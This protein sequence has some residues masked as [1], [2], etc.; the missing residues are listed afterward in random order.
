MTDTYDPRSYDPLS[1]DVKPN[2]EE[3]FA[4]LRAKCP[5]HHH[6]FTAEQLAKINNPFVSGRATEMYSFTRYADVERIVQTPEEFLNI[7]GSG[8][9]IMRPP[10]GEGTLT[11]SDGAAHSN[12]RRIAQPAFSPKVINPLAPLLQSRIDDLIDGFAESGAVDIMESFAVPLTS[13]MLAF[14][15]GLPDDDAPMLQE[16]AY[17]ILGMWGGDDEAVAR[18]G[19][20]I[21]GIS[22]FVMKVGPERIAAKERGEELN[23]GFTALLT[24][25]GPNGKTFTLE[26]GIDALAQIVAGGF[27]SSAT[28]IAN[29][30]YLLLSNPGERKKLEERPELIGTA[31]EEVLRYMAPIEGLFRTPASDTTLAGVDLAKG[32]KIRAVFAS[33]NMDDEVF[34]DPTTFRIDR[35]R[36]ELQKHMTFGKGIHSCLGNALARQELKL[37]FTTLF[38]RIPTLQLDP[39]KESRR[40]PLM[41]IHGYDYVPVVWDPQSVLPRESA[42][43][44]AATAG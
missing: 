33:A 25:V 1:S 10:S 32:T 11:W 16:W 8:P 14:L 34:S 6:Q 2:V 38:R 7:E 29:G 23:D 36:G 20:A 41:I 28:A 27:E 18:G 31:V 19:A 4:E 30:V 40:N 22:E 9:E 12:S 42:P 21:Q 24:T 26:Q 13:K 39:A 35:D 44:E 5:V 43:A 37:G 3:H 15:L 17:G